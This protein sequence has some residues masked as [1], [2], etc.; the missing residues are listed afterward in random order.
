MRTETKSLKLR[1][2]IERGR[3]LLKLT[4]LNEIKKAHHPK[5]K[6]FNEYIFNEETRAEQM[7][8]LVKN[9]LIKLEEDLK[10]LD[11]KNT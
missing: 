3:T 6:G 1:K 5:F 4:A 10:E 2:K 7:D 8:R 9:I 11:L